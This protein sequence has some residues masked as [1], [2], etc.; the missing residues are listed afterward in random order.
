M[1]YVVRRYRLGTA[2]ANFPAFEPGFVRVKTNASS[3]LEVRD[4]KN[5]IFGY[6]ITHTRAHTHAHTC[7]HARTL[8]HMRKRERERESSQNRERERERAVRTEGE[9]ESSQNIGI[10]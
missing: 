3:I 7:T 5:I 6:G 8:T 9:R 2:K 10:L 1:L 4:S